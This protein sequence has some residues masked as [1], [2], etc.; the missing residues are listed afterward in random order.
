MAPREKDQQLQRSTKVFEDQ[1]GREWV[2]T[3]HNANL[4]P[5][6][7]MYL[8]Q[9][10]QPIPTPSKYVRIVPSKMGKLHV[11]YDEWIRDIMASRLY[12]RERL[13]QVAEKSY[14]SA[15]AAAL[16]DP[17]G[18]LL[19]KL[20]PEPIP[21]EFVHAMKSGESKWALG[22]RRSDGSFY[23]RPKW[24]SDEM[25]QRAQAALKQVWT[26]GD[27]ATGSVDEFAAGTFADEEDA[28]IPV[29][30]VA[31]PFADEEGDDEPVAAVAPPLPGAMKRPVGRPRKS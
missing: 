25:W 6:G 17:P 20:G 31:S 18:E 14:G 22:I 27:T 7:E 8:R 16:K 28:T 19:A 3:L 24:V 2:V 1:H 10:R 12:R 5:V 21:V 13:Q 9:C 26:S 15:F 11:H 4:M 30:A 29:E 23:P